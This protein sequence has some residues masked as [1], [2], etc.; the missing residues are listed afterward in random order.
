MT[1]D[2]G[3]RAGG[4]QQRRPS[5]M[6]E[7]YGDYMAR[8]TLAFQLATSKPPGKRDVYGAKQRDPRGSGRE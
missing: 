5:R 6:T 8:R 3:S 2:N 4:E 1:K 7:V